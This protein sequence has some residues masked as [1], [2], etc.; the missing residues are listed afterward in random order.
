LIFDYAYGIDFYEV[1]ALTLKKGTKNTKHM[2]T[3][4]LAEVPSGSDLPLR[5][6]KISEQTGLSPLNLFQKWILQEESFIG[7]I[8]GTKGQPSKQAKASQNASSLK[9][10]AVK[11]DLPAVDSPNYREE[12]IKR[13][14]RLKKEGTPLKKIAEIF[15]KEKIPTVSGSGKWYGSSIS[16]LLNSKV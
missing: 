5:L 6:Q 13:A 12:L 1:T 9:E 8:Q 15:N 10:P 14:A 7:L 3:T 11:A 16:N 4:V 2:A